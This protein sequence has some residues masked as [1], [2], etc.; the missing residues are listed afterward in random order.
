MRTAH[1]ALLI[2]ALLATPAAADV[3]SP[4]VA[5]QYEAVF[6]CTVRLNAS[7]S[8][9]MALSPSGEPLRSAYRH[10][11]P[12]YSACLISETHATN[13]V[14]AHVAN[15]LVRGGLARALWLAGK[16][17]GHVYQPPADDD[18]LSRGEALLVAFTA[19]LVTTDRP[20]AEAYLRA[21]ADTPEAHSALTALQ[22]EFAACRPDGPSLTVSPNPLRAA[23][24]LQL[25]TNPA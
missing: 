13:Y 10:V 4:T 9:S 1:T 8:A 2:A 16:R 11:E 23:L 21:S 7:A 15:Y 14:S 6:A 22:P 5:Q 17:A 3:T 24:A 18:D 12:A 20:R 19:C 25:W